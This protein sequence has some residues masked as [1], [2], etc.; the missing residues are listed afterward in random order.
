MLASLTGD[1]ADLRP[2]IR[3]GKCRLSEIA[4]FM[5]HCIHAGLSELL[6]AGSWHRFHHTACGYSTPSRCAHNVTRGYST[7]SI[8]K[9]LAGLQQAA[10]PF[11]KAKV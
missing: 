7:A 11:V 3:I 5:A 1:Q 8:L 9:L 10:R 2:I 4:P 6:N